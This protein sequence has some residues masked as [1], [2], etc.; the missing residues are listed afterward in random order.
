MQSRIKKKNTYFPDFSGPGVS[1]RQIH[2]VY[3]YRSMIAHQELYVRSTRQLWQLFQDQSESER[4]QYS[5]G[6]GKG[7]PTTGQEGPEEE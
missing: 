4:P 3:C 5:K 1:P 7:H 2:Q 6:K